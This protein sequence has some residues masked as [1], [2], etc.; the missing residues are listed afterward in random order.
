MTKQIFLYLMS[1][2][3]VAAGINHFV[4]PKGYEKIIPAWLPNPIFLNYTSGVCEII[5]ALLLLPPATRTLGAWLIIVLLI[6]VFPANI[7]MSINYWQHQNP[8]FW[9]TVARLPLQFILIYWAFL[10]T[11]N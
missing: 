6:A 11:K 2:L 1:V 10:Y 4:H 3:Y 7:Q 9:F 8:R 5:F